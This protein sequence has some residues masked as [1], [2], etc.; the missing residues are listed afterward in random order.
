MSNS[1]K[2]INVPLSRSLMNNVFVIIISQASRKFFVIH[3]W[4]VFPHSPS[5]SNLQFKI[6]N[7]VYYYLSN[8]ELNVHFENYQKKFI[9][10]YLIWFMQFELPL[11]TGPRYDVLTGTICKQLKQELP[12][13][14]RT[15]ALVIGKNICRNHWLS[16]L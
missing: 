3:L 1:Y 14:Y 2:R 10:G 6:S 13:L 16:I 12:Q 5:S 15:T 11:F 4:L 8:V 9:I 7:T